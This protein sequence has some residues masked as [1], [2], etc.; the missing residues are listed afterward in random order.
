MAGNP[1]PYVPV[2][3]AAVFEVHPQHRDIAVRLEG[4][5]GPMRFRLGLV[6]ARELVR[7][8]RQALADHEQHSTDSPHVN[9]PSARAGVK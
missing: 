5:D 1:Q 7:L 9:D 6:E 3:V 2:S 4:E 8:L